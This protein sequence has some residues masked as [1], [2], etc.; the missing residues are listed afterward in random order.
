MSSFNLRIIETIDSESWDNLIR[1]SDTA[2]FFQ[3]KTCYDFYCSVNAL[4]PFI[5]AVQQSDHLVALVCGY[6]V[7]SKTFPINYLSRRAIIPGGLLIRKNC[8]LEAIE[9][10]LTHLKSELEQKNIYIEIRNFHDYKPWKKC[11]QNVGFD[12]VPHCNV[13][14]KL[15]GLQIDTLL[16]TFANEKQ[17]QLKKATAHQITCNPVQNIS[18]LDA[19][20]KLL[21]NFYKKE[22]KLP[23]FPVD[24]F[25]NLQHLTNAVILAVKQNN[26]IIGGI[27]LVHDHQTAYEWFICG[28]KD[29]P[30]YPSVVASAAGLQWAVSKGLKKFD[31]MGAGKAAKPSGIRDFKLRFGGELVEHGRYLFQCNTLIYRLSTYYFN[32]LKKYL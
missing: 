12:Y 13:Q 1:W 27:V 5:Y 3:T 20:Y 14:N 6:T 21:S 26:Q 28:D 9:L 24:F 2:S 25:I 18:E 7:T 11:F 15:E 32:H 29:N 30:F 10:L 23:L 22:I 17:R 19:F 31:F 4:T 16:K 8:Q